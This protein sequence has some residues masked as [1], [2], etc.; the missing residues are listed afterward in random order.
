MR[1]ILLDTNFLLVPY[2]FRIDIFS[3]LDE[4]IDGPYELLVPTGAVSEL[5]KI[6]RGKGRHAAAAR[7]ALKLAAARGLKK[8]RSSGKVDDWLVSTAAEKGFW[9]ATNDKLLRN[10]LKKAGVKAVVLRSRAG[11]DVV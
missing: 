9:V 6:S 10:R 5:K 1:R 4:L 7:F 8:V 3:R 2:Q 11:L